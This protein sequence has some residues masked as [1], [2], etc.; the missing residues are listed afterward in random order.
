M[1]AIELQ[2]PIFNFLQNGDQAYTVFQAIGL[3]NQGVFSPLI[4]RTLDSVLRDVAD[5]H[6]VVGQAVSGSQEF[7]SELPLS[8]ALLHRDCKRQEIPRC[9]DSY[10]KEPRKTFE[11][12][13]QRTCNYNS[14]LGQWPY[15]RGGGSV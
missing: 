9:R 10:C 13:S 4:L 6:L 3:K 14:R 8:H 12:S 1:R 11:R 5:A 15:C 7:R 2:K